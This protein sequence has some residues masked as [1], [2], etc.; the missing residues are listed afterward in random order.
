MK[1]SVVDLRYRMKEVLEALRRNEKVDIL[2][3]GKLTGTIYPAMKDK[4]IQ[5]IKSHPFFGMYRDRYKG[6]SVQGLMDELRGDRYAH[7]RKTR[8]HVV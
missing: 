3:H 7:L 1:A 4:K 2:Y 8:G 5:D 6:K